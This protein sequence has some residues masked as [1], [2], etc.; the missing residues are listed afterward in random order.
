MGDV[1]DIEG[2][3]G[4][5]TSIGIRSSV[6]LF[7]D[8]TETLIPNSSLLENNLTNWTFSNRT[9]RFTVSVGV[10]Y[11]S[12]TAHVTRLLAEVVERHGLVQK[13]PAPQVLLTD[14]C[15]STI[16]FEIR[17][18]VDVAK[19]NAAQVASDLRH[20]IAKAFAEHGIS[21]AFPQRDLHWDSKPL[22]VQ[23]TRAVAAGSDAP[24]GKA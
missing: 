11:G 24:S 13:E 14:F 16:S 4:T 3:R 8:G 17:F 22:Q 23:L 2:R 1:L 5:V 18:W 20:M 21:M 12:D 15:D 19:H 10:A 6:I 7:W 9:V